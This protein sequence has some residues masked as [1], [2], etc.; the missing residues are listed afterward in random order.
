[1]HEITSRLSQPEW[2]YAASFG[3]IPGARVVQIQG[4][5]P[6]VDSATLPES[7]VPFGGLYPFQ[8]AAQAHQIVSTSA[9]DAAAG[10]GVR[11]VLVQGLGNS[12]EELNEV[13]TLNGLTPV[14]LVNQYRRINAATALTVGAGATGTNVGEITVRTT[15]GA[16]PQAV[17]PVGYGR[18][19]CCVYTVPAG[20]GFWV[21]DGFASL[22]DVSNSAGIAAAFQFYGR[23]NG[24]PWISRFFFSISNMTPT[25]NI[26]PPIL[27]A[28]PPGADLTLRVTNA[29]ASNLLVTATLNGVLIPL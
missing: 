14:A 22:L 3:H 25:Y 5:N 6:D 27:R 9:D 19:Q 17:I 8:A 23:D 18:N 20:Y 28:M 12:H 1:M 2:L 4:I 7:T 24:G 13:V 11:T 29:S 16:I 15:V 10:L 21:I 26:R